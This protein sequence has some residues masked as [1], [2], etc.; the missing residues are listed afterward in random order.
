VLNGTPFLI[1][2]TMIARVMGCAQG[3]MSQ[4]AVEILEGDAGNAKGLSPEE[5]YLRR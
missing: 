5:A 4:W 2:S 3:Q 1:L